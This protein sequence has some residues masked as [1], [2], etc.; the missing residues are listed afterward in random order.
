LRDR[1]P[2]VTVG[3]PPA[4]C[5]SSAQ[6][7]RRHGVTVVLNPAPAQPLPDELLA[8][9]DYLVPSQTELSLLAGGVESLEDA[10]RAVR[11][12]L[13]GKLIVTLGGEGARV[14]DGEQ[15]WH[16]SPFKVTPV[17]TVAAGDAFIGALAAALNEGLPLDQAV[18][19]GNAA[20]AIA[21]TRPGAMTSL[22]SRAEVVELL[23]NSPA[24]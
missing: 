18:R 13:A 12:K 15:G 17:D 14:F 3:D 16:V 2:G 21:V 4:D 11:P 19:R 23:E 7:A 6:L 24:G 10:I 20:G 8:A 22:P 5:D 1:H 9:V